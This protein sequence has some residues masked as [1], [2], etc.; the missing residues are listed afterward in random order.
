M[1]AERKPTKEELRVI[2]MELARA[3]L[4]LQAQYPG[5]EFAVSYML[6]RPGEPGIYAQ[7]VMSTITDPKQLMVLLVHNA[8]EVQQQ[9]IDPFYVTPRGDS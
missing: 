5:L 2:G 9:C 7:S 3:L 6:P 4:P 1:T 8:N